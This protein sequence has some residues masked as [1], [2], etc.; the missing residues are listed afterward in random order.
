MSNRE[1]RRDRGRSDR[2][3]LAER[4]AAVQRE[5]IDAYREVF[6]RMGETLQT[7]AYTPNAYLSDVFDVWNVTWRSWSAALEATFGGRPPDSIERAQSPETLLIPRGVECWQFDV[8]IDIERIRGLGRVELKTSGFHPEDGGF[9]IEYP[10]NVDLDPVSIEPGA[11]GSIRVNVAIF[12]LPK[13]I[14]AGWYLG[15]IE[16]FPAS[17]SQPVRVKEIRLLVSERGGPP[18]EN[19]PESDRLD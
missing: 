1:K 16:A 9:S 19:P 10:R 3:E 11:L 2:L 7:G 14:R 4:W 13:M 17:S 18:L 15:S 8:E 5:S 12:S 6:Q